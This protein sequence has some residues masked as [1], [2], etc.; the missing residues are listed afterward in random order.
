MAVSSAS[1]GAD[2]GRH[3]L[4]AWVSGG[5]LRSTFATEGYNQ[6]FDSIV[7]Q[8]LALSVAR[9]QSPFSFLESGVR[10][11]HRGGAWQSG[12]APDGSL[13]LDGFRRRL[14]L[15]YVGVP[16]RFRITMNEGPVA[17]SLLVGME[18]SLLLWSGQ[19]TTDEMTGYPYASDDE[20]GNRTRIFELA[21]TLGGRI[22]TSLSE[23]TLFLDVTY[24]HGLSPV[25]DG[26]FKTEGSLPRIL[27]RT[28]R[29]EVGT[30]L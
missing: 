5:L 19:G 16:L 3:P 20:V 21:W 29:F 22:Q 26:D 24:V 15:L 30:R 7:G 1:A 11:E 18:G 13:G 6:D 4:T 2:S 25:D 14:D 27:N 12:F 8:T 9:E 28:Y 17:P 10:L 23:R